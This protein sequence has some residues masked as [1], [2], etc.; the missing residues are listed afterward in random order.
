MSDEALMARISALEKQ[1][2]DLRTLVD[3]L[4]GELD[5]TEKRLDDIEAAAASGGNSGGQSKKE[6]KKA[7]KAEKKDNAKKDGGKKDDK[8]EEKKFKAATKEGGKKGQDLSGMHDLG[9]MRYFTVAMEQCEGRWDLLQA[10]MDGANK[11]VDESGDDRK[12]G[13]GDLG[14]CFLSV[15]DADNVCRML[16]HMPKDKQQDLSLKEW[17]TVMI[18]DSAVQGT[19]LE[20]SDEVIKAECKGSTEK[21][22][23]PLKQR[24]SAINVSF[25]HLRSKQLVAEDDDDSE[26]DMG[27]MYEES[28]IEW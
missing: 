18:S 28:G 26:P 12:G 5:K 27:A 4:K 1:N 2:A 15:N 10:A 13:A 20:E 8:G 3:E 21:Q 25:A 11:E 17:A 23:F 7:A 6:K 19:I 24:D 22:L 9:G 16:F 14:K